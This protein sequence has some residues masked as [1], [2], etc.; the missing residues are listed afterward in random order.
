MC[1]LLWNFGAALFRLFR[2]PLLRLLSGEK[3]TGQ[4]VEEYGCRLYLHP[5]EQ[6][7]SAPFPPRAAGSVTVVSI[8]TI[9]HIDGSVVIT[10]LLRTAL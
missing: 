7:N 8:L 3:Q 2:W 5:E 1:L 6:S 10:P 9:G 4:T